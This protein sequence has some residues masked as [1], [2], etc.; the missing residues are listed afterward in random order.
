MDVH[1]W[2]FKVLYTGTGVGISVYDSSMSMGL[3]RRNLAPVWDV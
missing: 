3:I 2:S 1:I